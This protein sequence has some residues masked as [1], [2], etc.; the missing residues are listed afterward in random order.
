MVEQLQE[1]TADRALTDEAAAIR[2]AADEW[3]RASAERAQPKREDDHDPDFDDVSAQVT[4]LRDAVAALPDDDPNRPSMLDQL[5]AMQYGLTELTRTEDD[6]RQA[7]ADYRAA[8]NATEARWAALL[9]D[10]VSMGQT[11][12]R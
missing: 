1:L 6:L 7:I 12:N 4:Q 9:D 2:A 3:I 10:A 8:P 11:P 5:A